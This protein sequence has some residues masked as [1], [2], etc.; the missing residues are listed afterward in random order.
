MNEIKNY[1]RKNYFIKKGFQGR[2]MFNFYILLAFLLLV[3][4]ILLSFSTAEYLTITYENYDL[5]VASTPVMLFKHLLTVSWLIMIPLGLLMAWA[6]MRHTHRIAGPLYKFEMVLDQM[7]HGVLDPNVRLRKNDDGQDV[8]SK[9]QTT[10]RFLITKVLEIRSLADRLQSDP[11]VKESV[12]LQEIGAQ[13][14]QSLS[15]FEIIE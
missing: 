6:V 13:L 12:E 4:T 8:V 7:S 9:L 2:Y 15:E 3:F 11:Q 14:Q 10:N 1:R 5:K